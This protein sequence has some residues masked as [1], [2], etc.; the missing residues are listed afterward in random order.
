MLAVYANDLSGN[1]AQ[2]FRR[3]QRERPEPVTIISNKDLEG[4]EFLRHAH[5]RLADF[6]I[7]GQSDTE[8]TGFQVA[9]IFQDTALPEYAVLATW[10]TAIP[11]AGGA[12]HTWTDLSNIQLAKQPFVED[13]IFVVNEAYSSLH[14]WAEGS[15][16]V[17]DEILEEYFDIK[18]PWLFPVV[19]INQIVLQT[20]SN[21]CVGS[22]DGGSSGSSSGGDSGGGD[23]GGG[24]VDAGILCFEGDSQV[25]MI[26]GT[27]KA[28]RDVQVGD[29]VATGTHRGAGRV[30]KALKH[31]VLEGKAKLKI[32]ETA[33]GPLMGTPDHPVY[34]FDEKTTHAMW[35]NFGKLGGWNSI[36][37]VAVDTLYNLEIDAD[38]VEGSS[39]SYVVN[40]VVASGLGDSAVLN[41]R[42]PRQEA[43]KEVA[44][45]R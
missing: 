36:K 28:I 13:N 20:S 6:H 33:M 23:G 44:S 11:W 27:H 25:S 26:D 7:T 17:A 4:R 30:T 9:S 2:Y 12:W 29:F 21:E 24:S 34:I 31:P 35:I 3:F 42:F 40:G 16:K 39:H 18:R 10:N 32:F 1:K 15:L 19:D 43:W 22:P 41:M 8:L 38:D 14:G 37:E 5:G 45:R